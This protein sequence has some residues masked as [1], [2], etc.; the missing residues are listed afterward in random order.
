M[1]SSQFASWALQCI[2]HAEMKILV[3]CWVI[4]QTIFHS[5]F[6]VLTLSM[7]F[8]VIIVKKFIFEGHKYILGVFQGHFDPSHQFEL[9]YV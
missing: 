5:F 4:V 2:L 3:F 8:K 6:S 9:K 1:T 7:P